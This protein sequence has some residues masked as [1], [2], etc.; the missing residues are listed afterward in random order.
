MQ[1][2]S[3]ELAQILGII[4]S[5][6][7]EG[8][9]A[10]LAIDSRAIRHPNETL[11]IAID[12]PRRSGADYIEELIELGVK[13]VLVSINHKARL[14]KYSI[15]FY[16]VPDPISA[17]HQII[18][19]KRSQYNLPLIGITGSN[20]KT[21]TKEWL[22]EILGSR[23]SVV[24]SPK[25]Y[26][27]QIGVPLSLWNIE[28]R[29]EIGIFE[30]GVS[31]PG[32]MVEL[33]SMIKP[34]IG[35]LTNIGDAHQINFESISQKAKEK[36]KLFLHSDQLILHEDLLKRFRL[37]I[38]HITKEN[39]A[40]KIIS[41]GVSND[42]DIQ[43]V[44]D[45]NIVKIRYEQLDSVLHL[46][47]DEEFY[48]ENLGHCIAAI[49]VLGY[50]ITDFEDKIRMLSGVEMRL[51]KLSGIHQ[52]TLINDTYNADLDSLK[53]A[54]QFL[55]LQKEKNTAIILGPIEGVEDNEISDLVKLYPIETCILIGHSLDLYQ[56]L[57]STIHAV[58]SFESVD[59]FLANYD[60][61]LL[62]SY[63]ILIKGSRRAQ[64]DRVTAYYRQQTH[65]TYLKV[66]LNAIKN[67]LIQYS[68]L[69]NRKTKMMV[70]LKAEGY[71]LG[72]VALAKMLQHQRVDYFA[73]AYVD[74]G[75]KL[76]MAGIQVPILVLNPE[77][78]AIPRI[79][80]NQLEAEIYSID[81]WRSMVQ[82]VKQADTDQKVGVH[83][84]IESG[85][86]RLG[87]LASEIDE[88]IA[89]IKQTNEIE[90]K[91]IFSHLAASDDGAQDDFSQQQFDTFMTVARLILAVAPHAILHIV[92]TGGIVRH[93]QFHLDMVRLG[94]GLFGINVPNTTPLPL[95][96]PLTLIA[97]L[98]QVKRVQ[99][100]QTVG[101]GREGQ[102]DHDAWIGIVSIGYADGY[103]RDYR[104][105]RVFIRGQYYPIIGRICMDMIMIMIGK[106]KEVHV[107]DEVELIGD[108]I[109][110]EELADHAHTIPYE[111]ITSI[112]DRVQRLY[113]ED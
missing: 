3:A 113:Y 59:S 84:K 62:A 10:E 110:I 94:I 41:W 5:H 103:R 54:L 18:A 70:M 81:I 23:Q 14:E 31:L 64:L 39:G 11:F 96:N 44:F 4:P 88:L 79:L 22:S 72:S 1:T 68:Q 27:S 17:L 2:K 104:E 26:N 75:V 105:G 55:A 60:H 101:Y 109:S 71:G 48:H 100:S 65:T 40:L 29:H 85:M 52:T 98:T 8:E 93:P 107:G 99:A 63:S 95:Q 112:S 36:L 108:H 82:A 83:I 73:V 9:I 19:F 77:P 74:E 102:L 86:H 56:R 69:L 51:E 89:E 32:E 87:F 61:R 38:D 12:G 92:N 76:R 97:R 78:T 106:D 35:I 91:G 50:Q 67:N 30:A 20:G 33:E 25:S 53:I 21:I 16:F 47:K 66:H 42:A 28:S 43:I 6:I 49:L 45:Q 34:K 111:V 24:K 57:Q 80:E 13:H 15:A 7:I 58:V 37:E 46:R 90:I